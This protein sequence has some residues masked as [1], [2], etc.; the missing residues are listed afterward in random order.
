MKY[1]VRKK[2]EDGTISLEAAIM[3]PVFIFVIMFIYGIML[4]FSGQQLINHALIQ[5]SESL[6]IDSYADSKLVKDNQTNIV[7]ELYSDLITY[8]TK[9]SFLDN[10]NSRSN[11]RADQ[12]KWYNPEKKEQYEK[13]TDVIRRRF[14][15]YLTN[16]EDVNKGKNEADAILKKYGVK[17][18]IDGVDFSESV[19]KDGIMTIKAK[20][21]QEFIFDFQGLASFDREIVIKVKMW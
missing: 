8:D 7:Y 6:S 20:F 1:S 10:L 16:E 17:D 12:S 19:I 5:S 14:I 18:G 21:K 3:M 15:G 13:R 2:S 11:F 4:M 9:K